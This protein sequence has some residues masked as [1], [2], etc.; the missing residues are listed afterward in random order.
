MSWLLDAKKQ[1]LGRETI[2]RSGQVV[3]CG[4]SMFHRM[5]PQGLIKF[6]RP[7]D[8]LVHHETQCPAHHGLNC[9]FTHSILEVSSNPTE[10]NLLALHFEI[11]EDLSGVEGLVICVK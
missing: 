4:D 8:H 2:A 1:F 9:T 6:L 7:V 10:G 3:P 11:L 5:W